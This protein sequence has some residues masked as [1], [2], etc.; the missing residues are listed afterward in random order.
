MKYKRMK[1]K[2]SDILSA[3]SK[4]YEKKRRMKKET[5]ESIDFDFDKRQ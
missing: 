1:M 5:V 4:I 3:G 2:N